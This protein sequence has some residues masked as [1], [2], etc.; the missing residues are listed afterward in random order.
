MKNKENITKPKKEW[1]TPQVEIISQGTIEGGSHH[2][3]PETQLFPKAT[4]G[5]STFGYS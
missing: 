3:G 2:G 4:P 1:I 5:Q